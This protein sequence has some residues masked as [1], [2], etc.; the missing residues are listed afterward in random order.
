MSYFTLTV[1]LMAMIIL[2]LREGRPIIFLMTVG[3]LHQRKGI[4]MTTNLDYMNYLIQYK[5][6]STNWIT[7]L[8]KMML[9]PIMMF[10]I[11]PLQRVFQLNGRDITFPSKSSSTILP[12]KSSSLLILGSRKNLKIFPKRTIQ[13]IILSP[14]WIWYL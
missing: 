2:H 1:F 3:F 7:M 5:R 11:C 10:V 4:I 13:W 14:W 8:V 12:P 6:N 9:M